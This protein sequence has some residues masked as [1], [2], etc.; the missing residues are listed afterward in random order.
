MT[1]CWINARSE[2]A[3]TAPDDAPKAWAQERDDGT[4]RI[5]ETRLEGEDA[6]RVVAVEM[7]DDP[8]DGSYIYAVRPEHLA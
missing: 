7:G 8:P 5:L 4:I 1:T 6:T 3:S 2:L